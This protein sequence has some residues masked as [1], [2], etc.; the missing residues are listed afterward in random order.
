MADVPV[1]NDKIKIHAIGFHPWLNSYLGVMIT[2]WFMNL[3]LLPGDSENWDDIPDLTSQILSFPSGKYVFIMGFEPVIGKYQSCSLFSPMFEFADDTA[4]I[5]TA[6]IAIKELMN[7]E[8]IE[9]GDIHS[10][11]IEGIWNGDE[12]KIEDQPSE[13]YPSVQQGD[14]NRI[15]LSK[16]MNKPLNRRQLLRGEF[17]PGSKNK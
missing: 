14:Q 11:Q 17:L 13:Q 2:P 8:N 12:Q 15:T 7:N 9:Q 16:R 5:E 6:K 4:A 3:M 1:I 10:L